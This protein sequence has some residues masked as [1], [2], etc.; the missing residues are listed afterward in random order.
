MS[1]ARNHKY[2]YKRAP[3]PRL[4][5][6][7]YTIEDDISKQLRKFDNAEIRTPI[8]LH[9]VYLTT[10][11]RV[12][13]DVTDTIKSTPN[14][15]NSIHIGFSGLHNFNIIAQRKSSRALICDINPE[16]ALFFYFVLKILCES[17]DR[18]EFA[19]KIT[20][21]LDDHEA[22]KFMNEGDDSSLSIGFYG[23]VGDDNIYG[24]NPLD[25][26]HRQL[27]LKDSWLSTDES[28]EF[29]KKLA[30]DDKIAVITENILATN[31]FKRI[32][33]YLDDQ[34]INID[35]LYISNIQNYIKDDKTQRLLQTVQSLTS[36]NTLLINADV[37]TTD[38]FTQTLGQQVIR[39]GNIP[40]LSKWIFPRRNQS[41][42]QLFSALDELQIYGEIL[43]S[44]NIKKGK[45]I[46]DLVKSAN[47]KAK[48][49]FSNEHIEAQDYIRFKREFIGL[50][51]SKN[52][53]LSEYRVNLKTIFL[54]IGIALTGIGA[55][56]IGA[57]L[58]HSYITY[59][60]FVFFGSCEKTTSEQKLS[61]V[62]SK[63]SG[64]QAL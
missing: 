40:S 6:T 61:N 27:Q 46:T 26:I 10:N 4:P 11:E 5:I 53:Q 57:K 18:F 36:T 19:K 15:P 63:I 25:Q 59:N 29:I 8:T 23:N 54:N 34:Q 55:L 16:N 39:A 37:V 56:A 50:L 52:D 13:N 43:T 38:S 1:Q 28:F 49:F 21:F 24:D 3:V 2:K 12:S 7:D 31:T 20:D 9:E 60:R 45:I 44:H 51:N 47:S 22:Y 58:V 32:R 42:L 14:Q 17:K 35:S 64:I 62:V 41:N 48:E 30:I 33:E